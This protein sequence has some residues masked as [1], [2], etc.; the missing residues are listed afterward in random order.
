M[1]NNFADESSDE[2]SYPYSLNS[3]ILQGYSFEPL[4]SRRDFKPS[5]NWSTWLAL[6][7]IA[8]ACART[9]KL[10]E[11]SFL[12]KNGKNQFSGKNTKFSTL[13]QKK[14]FVT[15]FDS[16]PQMNNIRCKNVKI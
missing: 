7:L 8:N 3:N 6:V 13:F 1:A 12:V 11:L 9:A 14:F 4:K 2:E 15:F 10:Y 5:A 16:V